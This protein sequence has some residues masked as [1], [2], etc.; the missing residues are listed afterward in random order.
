MADSQNQQGIYL[1]KQGK[2]FGPFTRA[3]IE[4]LKRTGD[5]LTYSF[6]WD[7]TVSPDWKPVHMPPSPPPAAAE[8][9]PSR[10]ARHDDAT[11]TEVGPRPV[12]EEV[13]QVSGPISTENRIFQVIC[14]NNRD[15]IGGILAQPSLQGF[16]LITQATSST[17]LPFGQG[18]KVWINLLDEESGQTEN[19][20]ALIGKVAS[21]DGK[22]ALQ[23]L[24]EK[25]AA[26]L[27]GKVT[28]VKFQTS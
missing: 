2:V 12:S 16:L 5:F 22:W 21:H 8:V 24:W 9:L 27:N 20:Q 3:Q 15:A 6:I 19:L 28:F 14:H 17:L 26:L 25:P 18:S 13:T 7:P 1:S 11:I 23:V 10:F 4:Q